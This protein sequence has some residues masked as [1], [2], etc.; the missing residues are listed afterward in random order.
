MEWKTNSC[1]AVVGKRGSGKSVFVKEVVWNNLQSCVC[2]DRKHEHSFEDTPTAHAVPELVSFWD[3]G[4]EKIVYQP[5]DSSYEDFD[6]FCQAIFYKGNTTVWIDETASVTT[7][8]IVPHW[9][10][11]CMRLG[12]IRGIGMVCV[13]QRPMQVSNLMFSE[14]DL[15]VS[16]RLNLYNDSLKIA[17][18]AG[19]RIV[20][21]VMSLDEYCFIVSDGHE[22]Q[23]CTPLAFGEAHDPSEESVQ[24]KLG[25]ARGSAPITNE[26]P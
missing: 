8:N 3:Q 25:G 24:P 21:T 10:G 7:A 22:T 2:H 12:R 1:V 19:E 11:E 4:Y 23:V 14:A 17:Q 13:T 20:P 9:Y 5:W 18:I 6:S 16:F 15:V 26:A